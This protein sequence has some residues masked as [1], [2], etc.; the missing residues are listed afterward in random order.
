MNITVSN[1]DRADVDPHALEVFVE[2]ILVAEGVDSGAALAV[3]FASIDD[4][5][6]LNERFMGK[7]GPTDVLS[8]P[9]EDASPGHSPHGVDGGPPLVLG[10]IFICTDVV[11]THAIEYGVSF[12]EELY[13]M[14][15]HGVLH[16]LGWDHVVESD[17]A[18]ME[19]RESTHLATVGR[20][21]R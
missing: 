14:V 8:F 10:D 7:T 4:I 20:S 5:A 15:V 17:A 13:L 9:I 12:D 3:T 16:I 6:D 18:A 1:P 19:S 21:R 2:A 11:D